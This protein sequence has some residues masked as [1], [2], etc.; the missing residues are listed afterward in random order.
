MKQLSDQ[1]KIYKQSFLWSILILPMIFLVQCNSSITPYKSTEQSTI[2][3]ATRL[4]DITPGDQATNTVRP[5]QQITPTEEISLSLTDVTYQPTLDEDNPEITPTTSPDNVWLEQMKEFD[6]KNTG[7]LWVQVY[8]NTLLL[9]SKFLMI[10]FE[11]ETIYEIMDA[12]DGC[13]RNPIP[14][15]LWVICGSK[16]FYFYNLLTKEK[17]S[18]PITNI[19]TV[20]NLPWHPEKVFYSISSGDK[21]WSIF[22]YHLFDKDSRK[23]AD[24]SMDGIESLPLL[25]ADGSHLIALKYNQI[26]EIEMNSGRIFPLTSISQNVTMNIGFSPL[27]S[28]LVYG[29]T[30]LAIQPVELANSMYLLDLEDQQEELLA[31]PPPEYTAFNEFDWPIW[32]HDG[33]KIATVSGNAICIIDLPNDLVDCRF[34]DDSAH[35]IS[36]GIHFL[37]WSPDDKYIAFTEENPDSPLERLLIYSLVDDTVGVLLENLYLGLLFW[38]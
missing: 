13:N 36:N 38:R 5:T 34:M 27:N 29:V 2:Y 26:V 33:Q 9:D 11:D 24:L 28:Q 21:H 23:L 37:T 3:T 14:D 20:W 6:H 19:E 10:D 8:E 32:S 25:S 7:Q 15:T 12:P 22:E 35:A 17:Q 1:R 30:D 4:I 16:N 31:T 18:L